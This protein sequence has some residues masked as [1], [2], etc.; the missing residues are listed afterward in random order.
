M[1]TRVFAVRPPCVNNPEKKEPL[2]MEP[3]SA[4]LA[5]SV[6]EDV[7]AE[8]SLVVFISNLGCVELPINDPCS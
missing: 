1:R 3:A 8:L 7:L 5:S 4:V 6:V 2:A